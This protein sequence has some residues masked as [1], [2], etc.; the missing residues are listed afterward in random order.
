MTLFE[1]LRIDHSLCIP[2]VHVTE[3][4]LDLGRGL[5]R[6]YHAEVNTEL[7]AYLFADSNGRL[8]HECGMYQEYFHD[9]LAQVQ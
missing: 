3:M 8:L 6:M 2:V 9:K 4:G 7:P 5:H 1:N